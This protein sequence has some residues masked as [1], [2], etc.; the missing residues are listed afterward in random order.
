M[1]GSGL[2][3]KAHQRATFIYRRENGELRLAHLHHSVS[4]DD[5]KDDE[6][7]P[8]RAA[9]ASYEQLQEMLGQ[10]EQQIELMLSQL[11]GGMQI[12]KMMNYIPPDGSVRACASSWAT[13]VRRNMR[14]EPGIA[15]RTSFCLKIL[16]V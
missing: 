13:A 8:V 11:P 10:R 2:Y 5:V 15:V 4:Y 14:T 9:K 3:M 16:K 7:F 1:E 6:L 12:C